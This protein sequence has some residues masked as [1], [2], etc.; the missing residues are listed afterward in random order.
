MK[1]IYRA[2]V[3]R[4]QMLL[5]FFITIFQE[6]LTTKRTYVKF[7]TQVQR[8]QSEIINLIIIQDN[9]IVMK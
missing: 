4:V 3:C 1:I 9:G 6:F 8:S 7:D 2:F 5:P